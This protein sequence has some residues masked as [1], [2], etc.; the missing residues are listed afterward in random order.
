M[1]LNPTA[2]S[3]FKILSYFEK[4][5]CHSPLRMQAGIGFVFLKNQPFVDSNLLCK[6]F[7]LFPKGPSPTPLWL[8]VV[9]NKRALGG[10]NYSH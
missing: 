8:R 9:D 4:K 3:I 2:L 5:F 6:F 7:S 1:Q 10:N